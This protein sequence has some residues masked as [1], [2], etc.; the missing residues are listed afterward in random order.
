M[1]KRYV[2]ELT[3]T[4][5]RELQELISKGRASALRQRRARILLKADVGPEGPGWTDQQIAEAVEVTVLTVERT[6]RLLVEQGLDKTLEPRPRLRP[7][8]EPKLDGAKEAHL[9]ALACS[10]PPKGQARWTLRLLADRFVQLGHVESLS[11]ETV[12]KTLKK[13]S[14]TAPPRVLGHPPREER[15]IRLAHGGRVERLPPAPG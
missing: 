11:H 2:V 8:R 12:R 6:R 15:R 3:S 7:T 9:I 1:A 13:R 4:E 14:P 5:R 10:D